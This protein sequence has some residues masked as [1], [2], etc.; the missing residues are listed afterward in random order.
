VT[1]DDAD[2]VLPPMAPPTTRL[3]VDAYTMQLEAMAEAIASPKV[4]KSAE[5]ALKRIQADL[6]IETDPN[7]AADLRAAL[8]NQQKILLDIGTFDLD[9][10]RSTM[11]AWRRVRDQI[12]SAGWDLTLEIH[13]EPDNAAGIVYAYP[14]GGKKQPF[15]AGEAQAALC[16]IQ[17][18]AANQER[19]DPLS[20]TKQMLTRQGIT[21][22]NFDDHRDR[23]CV[24]N[25]WAPSPTPAARPK[26]IQGNFKP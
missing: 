25:P 14:E 5:D 21:A 9:G 11:A 20:Y 17:F 6:A 13:F 3:W 4:R 8:Q 7:K 1:P 15:M 2:L 18:V 23:L 26:I 16:F 22:D 12:I 10:Y 19:F 24:D